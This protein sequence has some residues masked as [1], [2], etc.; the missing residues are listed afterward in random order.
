MNTSPSFRSYFP[1]IGFAVFAFMPGCFD[2]EIQ[3]D[4]KIS[5]SIDLEFAPI[6][7]AGTETI[8]LEYGT[9]SISYESLTEGEYAGYCIID[10]E[11]SGLLVNL[12]E[13]RQDLQN[14]LSKNDMT[15]EDVETNVESVKVESSLSINIETGSLSL[16]TVSYLAGADVTGGSDQFIN[17]QGN[18]VIT[19][20]LFTKN[21]DE[22]SK[23]ASTMETALAGDAKING[24]GRVI[25]EVSPEEF[26]KLTSQP[27]V[28]SISFDVT[29]HTVNTVSLL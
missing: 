11:Y 23:L 13:A 3:Y 10:I 14:E 26:S 1:W 9:T 2:M 8:N 22:S 19:D 7:C 5:E 6:E 29:A 27:N 17:I 20:E 24:W 16:E 12:I 28:A 15:L 25:L 4:M 18:G 21:L